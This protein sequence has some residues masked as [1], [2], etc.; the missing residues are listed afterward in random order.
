MAQF[1]FTPAAEAFP[2]TAILRT[3]DFDFSSA[4]P[5]EWT[6]N[7]KALALNVA[8]YLAAFAA[9]QVLANS[10]AGASKAKAKDG[11]TILPQK[12]REALWQ[13]SFDKRLKALLDGEGNW[14]GVFS[15][16]RV[17]PLEAEANKVA[18]E[19]VRA[20]H[21]AKGS[22]VPKAG[23]DEFKAQVARMRQSKL[24]AE[25]MVKA[26][27]RLDALAATAAFDDFDLDA[28]VVE[29]PEVPVLV[30]EADGKVRSVKP[31]K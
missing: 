20:Y 16:E 28:P 29:E 31:G 13:T 24:G 4:V 7:G 3:V 19:Y 14:E 12:D 26:Q 8:Q 1:K 15:G 9:K 10:I 2:G 27:A 18:A 11:K 30:Q 22:T 21:E 23:S 5:T 17:S 25:I 6:I